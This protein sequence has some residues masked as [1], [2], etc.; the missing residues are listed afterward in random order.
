MVFH[1]PRSDHRVSLTLHPVCR[2]GCGG[3]GVQWGRPHGWPTPGWLLGGG[4]PSC[5]MTPGRWT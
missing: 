5:G 1:K 2:A 3:D 4:W